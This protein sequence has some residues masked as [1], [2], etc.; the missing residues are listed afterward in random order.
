MLEFLLVPDNF[1]GHD[2][3]CLV[4]HAFQ[5]LSE[6]AFAQEI[7]D[8]ESVRDLILEYDI[9]I[10]S[11]VIVTAVVL[12]VLAALDLVCRKPQEVACL[13]VQDLALLVLR[14]SW[15]LQVMLQDLCSTQRQLWL[16]C[17]DPLLLLSQCILLAL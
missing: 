15:S 4:I 5:C 16:I 3:S 11:F 10:A 9:V 6:R 14:E 2:L 17:F 8:L 1:D 7:D 12:M 13:V